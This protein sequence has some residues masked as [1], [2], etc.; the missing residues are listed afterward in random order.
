MK[1]ER[2]HF[3]FPNMV[4]P[5]LQTL[6]WFLRPFFVSLGASAETFF[7]FDLCLERKI[8]E[9]RTYHFSWLFHVLLKVEW[10]C[11]C[12]Q[13]IALFSIFIFIDFLICASSSIFLPSNAIEAI[14]LFQIFCIVGL[15]NH[16]LK[17]I[18]FNEK[19]YLLW[20]FSRMDQIKR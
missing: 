3:F 17:I 15:W 13:V 20:P 10:K 4:M 18:V 11:S 6:F 16:F 5:V 19:R 2:I 1:L 12:E 7:S 9:K 8:S 14:R